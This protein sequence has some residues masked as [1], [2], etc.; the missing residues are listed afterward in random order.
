VQFFI[1]DEDGQPMLDK[2]G[3][4]RKF[5]APHADFS[6]FGLTE[7]LEIEQLR[8]IKSFFATSLIQA[9]NE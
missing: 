1:A 8:E 7:G 2:K 3:E 5:Y 4:V 9:D 6:E